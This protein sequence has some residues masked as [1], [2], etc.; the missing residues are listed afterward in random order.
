MI[1]ETFSQLIFLFTY[2]RAEAIGFRNG[3]TK[4]SDSSPQRET[5][6]WL[7]NLLDQLWRVPREEKSEFA[8][9]STV[10][11]SYV[12]RTFREQRSQE[13]YGGLEPQLSSLIGKGIVKGLEA[14]KTLRPSDIA[15]VSLFSLSLGK[16]APVI[17]TVEV[18]DSR[19]KFR[20]NATRVELNID[21]DA[22]FED[23]SI[24]LGKNLTQPTSMLLY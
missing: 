9:E 12:L 13:S 21:L 11:P 2:R 19:T 16:R 22:L 15:Y 17:R 7:N 18:L 20:G 1:S 8:Y 24:V 6:V 14:A 4:Y 23:M 3:I 5:V 10:Y